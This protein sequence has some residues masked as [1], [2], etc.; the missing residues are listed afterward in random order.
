MKLLVSLPAYLLVS[1]RLILLIIPR[2]YWSHHADWDTMLRASNKIVVGLP[3]VEVKNG[4]I[5]KGPPT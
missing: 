5:A 4:L 1:K 2:F 3:L